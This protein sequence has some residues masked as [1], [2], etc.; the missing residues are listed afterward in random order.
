M[1]DQKT[2]QKH[3][4]S[5]RIAHFAM[6]F[7]VSSTVYASPY[8][9]SLGLSSAE[10]G[11]F[12][13]LRSVVGIVAPIIWGLACDKKGSIKKV[14]YFCLI[15]IILLFP[16]VPST[17]R[18]GAGIMMLAPWVTVFI[19]FFYRPASFLLSNW[20]VQSQKKYP[21]LVM[22]KIR[23]YSSFASFVGGI[24]FSR[25]VEK[26]GL[27]I[28]Y[29]LGAVLALIVLLTSMSL[30]DIEPDEKG[31]KTFKDLHLEMLVKDPALFSFVIFMVCAFLPSAASTMTLPYLL[32][33][34]GG[35]IKYISYFTAFSALFGIPMLFFADK[36]IKRFS[37]SRVM[38]VTVLVYGLGELAF[39]VLKSPSLIIPMAAVIGAD[40]SLMNLCFIYY[41]VE[42]APSELKNTVQMLIS[43]A[44]A[45]AS[46]VA[47][48][49]A[50][51]MIDTSGVRPYYFV[52]FGLVFVAVLLFVLINCYLIKEQ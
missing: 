18:I 6:G 21:D 45:C 4:I 27:N 37:V 23:I 44:L 40:S 35:S 19:R 28:T 38:I 42:K 2:V 22:G 51:M 43:T 48:T 34:I 7:F 25:L 8:L 29:Y 1:A 30:P 41:G 16:M 47:G 32:D 39:A 11:L 33:D 49:V 31:T 20:L 13:S 26:S 10:V 52:S 24:M 3:K 9:K 15:G 17:A 50:G 46:I 36:I 14:F 12:T 5:F